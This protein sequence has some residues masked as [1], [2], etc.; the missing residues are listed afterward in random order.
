MILLD[1]SQVAHI[2]RLSERTLERYRTEG[3]GPPFLKFGKRVLYDQ[4]AVLAWAQ[5][6]SRRSTSDTHYGVEKWR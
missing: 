3:G 2:L 1:T 6:H 4:D 5:A